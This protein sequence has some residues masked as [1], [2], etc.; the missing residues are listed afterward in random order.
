MAAK[1]IQIVRYGK[2]LQEGTQWDN[3]DKSRIV[4][5]FDTKIGDTYATFDPRRGKMFTG[6]V[7]R[8]D[9]TGDTGD[10]VPAGTQV[11][12]QKGETTELA[13]AKAE[14]IRLV[15]ARTDELIDDGF[16][17][18]GQMFSLS[19]Q[20]Q[21]KL[22]GAVI[23]SASLTY[24]VEWNNIDDTGTTLLD[25]AAEVNVFYGTAMLTV[26]AHLATGTALKN[27]INACTTVAEVDAIQDT[28]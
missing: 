13:S 9:G 27:A 12:I 10:I 6:V 26:E 23:G 11:R 3:V 22:L 17:Y 20:A 1:K 18:D 24:P 21:L 15:D 8:A 28:R 7:K 4:F 14:K 5:H 25:D 19:E 16:P 2:M